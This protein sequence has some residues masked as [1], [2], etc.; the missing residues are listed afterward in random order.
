MCA[1]HRLNASCV[2]SYV[3]TTTVRTK[4]NK[5]HF[6]Q[7]LYASHFQFIPLSLPPFLSF[8]LPLSLLFF[9]LFL[10]LF[11]FL[12]T[13]IPLSFP[14]YPLSL[15]LHFFSYP[16]LQLCCPGTRGFRNISFLPSI[17]MVPSP[18]SGL[19]TCRMRSKRESWNYFR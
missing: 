7:W 15:D 8:S 12:F 18:P 5:F 13:F 3:L 2:L 4:Y 19:Q 11:P 10:F 17:R 6:N 9:S 14:L 16:S 1:Y